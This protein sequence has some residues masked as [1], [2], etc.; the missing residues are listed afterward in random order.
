MNFDRILK[1]LHKGSFEICSMSQRQGGFG[2]FEFYQLDKEPIWSEPPHVHI[3]V[4]KGTKGWNGK[5]LYDKN[6]WLSIFKV[7]LNPNCKY[8]N[9]NIVVLDDY[10]NNFNKIKKDVIHWLNETY[11]GISNGQNCLRDYLISNGFGKFRNEYEKEALKFVN[12][13]LIKDYK[14][15]V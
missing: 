13:N 1:I 12:P 15:E 4:K 11:A 14:K 8:T 7:K 9:E 2:Q 5:G 3:C 6:S 10:G